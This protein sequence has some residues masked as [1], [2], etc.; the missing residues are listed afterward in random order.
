M[1]SD[2]HIANSQTRVATFTVCV[3]IFAGVRGK[4]HGCF[5]C[6]SGLTNTAE[7][8]RALVATV[9]QCENPK[10]VPWPPS[11]NNEGQLGTSSQ[12]MRSRAKGSQDREDSFMASRKGHHLGWEGP[13]HSHPLS[14]GNR[15]AENQGLRELCGPA[16][17]TEVITGPQA[18]RAWKW[19][20]RVIWVR[21]TER[22]R[23][24][25]K[26][27]WAERR[28]IK[29]SCELRTWSQALSPLRKSSREKLMEDSLPQPRGRIQQPCL[30]EKPVSSM[31]Q[32]TCTRRVDPRNRTLG[33]GWSGCNSPG[34]V[35]LPG[36]TEDSPVTAFLF[37]TPVITLSSKKGEL[38][39]KG[40]GGCKS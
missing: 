15:E 40:V 13:R 28:V 23:E 8:L 25:S 3:A 32:T 14:A 31:P 37:D 2:P 36:Q 22:E 9:R 7:K 18:L 16:I 30:S 6:P 20:G 29:V 26:W 33:N 24:E 39:G 19:W 11:R 17:I 10:A 4:A 38:P 5:C 1:S 12:Q 27:Q 34:T 21:W 35:F